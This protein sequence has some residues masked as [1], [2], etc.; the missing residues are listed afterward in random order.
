MNPQKIPPPKIL[1]L[2]IIGICTTLSRLVE[3]FLLRYGSPIIRIF[4][5][6]ADLLQFIGIHCRYLCSFQKMPTPLRMTTHLFRKNTR[7][8][9]RKTAFEK[10]Y[11]RRRGFPKIGDVL[12]WD[13]NMQYIS[14]IYTGIAYVFAIWFRRYGVITIA[15]ASASIVVPTTS[16]YENP[17]EWC[18][19]VNQVIFTTTASIT[20]VGIFSFSVNGSWTQL[21]IIRSSIVAI[22]AYAGVYYWVSY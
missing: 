10:I 22:H 19:A 16:Y 4:H 15:N 5:H 12:F 8:H 14:V 3:I 20:I 1:K 18:E 11:V 6:P 9:P 17:T 2:K 13:E 7:F 21:A